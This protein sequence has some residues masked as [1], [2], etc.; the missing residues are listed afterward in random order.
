MGTC[1]FCQIHTGR[2]PASFVHQC[3]DFMAIMDIHPMRAGHVLIIPRRHLQYLHELPKGMRDRLFGLGLEIGNAWRRLGAD[4]LNY[5]VNDGR[6]ANQ[7]VPHL[8]LHVI[9]RRQGDTVR[10][11]GRLMLKPLE[12]LLGPVA[13]DKLD[14]QAHVLRATLKKKA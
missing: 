13:R 6:A 10:L 9:P 4:G 11:L 3:D 7:S 14:Q 8:H 12:P 2:A 5:V 1:V